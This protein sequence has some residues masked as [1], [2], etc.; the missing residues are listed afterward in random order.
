MADHQLKIWPH[1]FNAVD[2][3]DKP[4]EVRLDDRGYQ[5]G[6]TLVLNEWDDRTSEYSG[7]VTR[8]LVTYIMRGGQ[9]GLAEGHVVMALAR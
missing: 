9:F 6:D 1:F 5:V 8:K 3:G 7:R 4:F 2:S